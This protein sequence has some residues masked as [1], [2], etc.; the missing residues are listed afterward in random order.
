MK[1]VNIKETQN[2]MLR[3]F[4]VLSAD[5]ARYEFITKTNQLVQW[6]K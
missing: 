2:D 3:L 6:P 1:R 4:F 5:A